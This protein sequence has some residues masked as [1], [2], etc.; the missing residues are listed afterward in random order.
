MLG[1]VVLSFLVTAILAAEVSDWKTGDGLLCLLNIY[2]RSCDASSIVD[3]AMEFQSL[4]RSLKEER[5]SHVTH[6]L[7]ITTL[8]AH[9]FSCTILVHGAEL[10]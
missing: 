9:V 3:M 10:L 4:V 5:I 2:L 6:C 8:V 7:E 1:N